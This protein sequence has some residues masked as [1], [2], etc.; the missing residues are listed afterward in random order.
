MKWAVISTWKMAMEATQ[1]AADL[2][3][4]NNRASDSVVEGVT[5]VEDD[6]RYCSVGLSGLPDK[7]GRITLD[8]GFM[9]GDTLRFGAVGCIEGFRSPIRIAR[10]LAECEFNNFLV[11]AGA[12]E[13]ARENGFQQRDNMTEDTYQK[14]LKAKGETSELKSYDGHDTVCMIG[15][16]TSDSLAVAVS[17]S[18]L[19]MKHH[20][21][22]GDSPV[23]G[24]GFYA[25]SHIGSAAVTGVGEDCIR[26]VFSYTAVSKMAEGK[27][28]QQA[29]DETLSQFIRRTGSCRSISIIAMDKDGNYGVATNCDFTFVYVSDRQP[30]TLYLAT[31][32]GEETVIR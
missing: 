25:D 2:L 17:T 12:E 18:G 26:G 9:D 29:V 28:V 21:R 1:K 15:K 30:P 22:L 32:N 14:Y 16:D 23:A 11:G 27:S 5:I 24:A 10:S 7:D 8:G 6:P 3:S 4:E 19:F 20:G 31:G 13:Y